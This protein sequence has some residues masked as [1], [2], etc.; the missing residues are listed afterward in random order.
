[1]DMPFIPEFSDYKARNEWIKDHAQY[2]TV[3]RRWQRRYLRE[4]RH[5]Y[6]EAIKFAE[7]V[8]KLNPD[9]RLLIYAVALSHDT[10]VAT[11]SSDGVK[12]HE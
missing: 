4:E 7:W 2:F 5:T 12:C 3:I 10:L 9:A 8:V 6:D 1:M 11:V